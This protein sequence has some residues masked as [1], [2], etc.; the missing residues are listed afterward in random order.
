[1]Q[2]NTSNFPFLMRLQKR[3]EPATLHR[4]PILTK[5]DSGV[6]YFASKPN[7]KD[8]Q[9]L[10]LN[11][12]IKKVLFN[13]FMI[14]FKSFS[15]VKYNVVEKGLP[16]RTMQFLLISSGNCLGLQFFVAS[17]IALTRR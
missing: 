13:L 6:M 15:N 7:F 9:F 16:D 5:M 1:M 14:I 12:N 3:L 17:L 11:Q 10:L 4:S 2:N 8:D